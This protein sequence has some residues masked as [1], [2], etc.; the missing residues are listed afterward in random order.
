[1]Q[2]A[3]FYESSISV[4]AVLDVFP[5]LFFFFF[6]LST[7]FLSPPRP[8]PPWSLEVLESYLRLAV[9]DQDSFTFFSYVAQTL[10]SPGRGRTFPQG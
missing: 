9:S 10:P 1:L 8:F 7:S 6:L 4:G 2:I 3:Q 5:I